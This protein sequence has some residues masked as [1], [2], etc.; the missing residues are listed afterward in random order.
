MLNE[1]V[2]EQNTVE[3]RFF[4][5]SFPVGPLRCN[6]TILGDT[7][8]G[9]AIVADP[10]GNVDE[11]LEILKAAGLTLTRIIHTHAHF[12]HFLA[13]GDLHEQTGAPLC[14]HP[15]DKP[16][17][18]MLEAQCARFRIPY[19]PVPE[20]HQWLEDNEPLI[21]GELTG[22]A[23]WTPGHSPGS[24]SFWFE[25]VNLLIAGDTLF[26][27]G[28]GRT[29]LWGGNSATLAQSIRQRLYTLDENATVIAGH[30]PTTTLGE[31]MRFN[32]HIRA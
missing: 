2:Q 13:S 19:K 14:L 8:T 24:M 18:E 26:K 32:P 30:G 7:V 28:V 23:L 29:D 17:W 11:I 12:D 3:Y 20:P 1:D 22:K 15:A 6:C 31:E 10:G 9:Q 4:I 5:R 16:L 21:A 27:G 25:A